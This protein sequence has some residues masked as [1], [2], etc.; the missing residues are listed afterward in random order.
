MTEFDFGSIPDLPAPDKSDQLFDSGDDWWHNACLNY[1]T[2]NWGLYIG[3]YMRAGDVLVD[4]ISET[5]RDQDFLVFPIVFV[6][7]QYLELRLKK[8]IRDMRALG[9]EKH[10]FPKT[11]DLSKLWAD[12]RRLLIALEPTMGSEVLE[13]V[14]EGIKQFGDL[15]P[16]S[17]SFRYPVHKDGEKS[18]PSDLKYINVRKLAEV[19]GKLNGFFEAVTMMVSEHIDPE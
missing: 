11:H 6:Y 13:G 15:D 18:L 3:G 19:M 5:H 9:N 17:D 1:T 8:L 7:R 4:H 16:G 10:A 14:D 2:D 12:C